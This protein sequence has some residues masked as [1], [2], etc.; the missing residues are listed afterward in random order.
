LVAQFSTELQK[1]T[2]PFYE[3]TRLAN[4]DGD[5]VV[6]FS[7]KGNDVKELAQLKKVTGQADVLE[8]TNDALK[9]DLGPENVAEFIEDVMAEPKL[10]SAVGQSGVGEGMARTER[11]WGR[12]TKQEYG[13]SQDCFQLCG[14]QSAKKA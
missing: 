7:R 2:E 3:Q 9:T 4:L 6:L 13:F 5:A 11:C 8:I 14:G 10:L 12:T 1:I